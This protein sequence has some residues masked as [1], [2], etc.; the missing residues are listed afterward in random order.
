ME[1]PQKQQP[2]SL[3]DVLN[4]EPEKYLSDEEVALVRTFTPRHLNVIR[5][6]MLPT[7]SD[8]NLPIEE[9]GKDAFLTGVDWLSMPAE[10]VKAIMQ[11]R[12]EAIK[13]ILGGLVQMRM[14]SSAPTENPYAEQVRR[15]K[16]STK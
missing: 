9:M 13:F 7:L 10:H 3:R 15:A 1:Q 5:K 4:Y 8:P 6:I 11:G 12:M 14:I 16:D 2:A